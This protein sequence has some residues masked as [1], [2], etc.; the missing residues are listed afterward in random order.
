MAIEWKHLLPTLVFLSWRLWQ[1]CGKGM[2]VAPEFWM[3]DCSK[4][5]GKIK[6]NCF[7][8]IRLSRPLF[9]RCEGCNIYFGSLWEWTSVLTVRSREYAS[10]AR[11]LGE[12][13]EI[14]DQSMVTSSSQTRNPLSATY[15]NFFH[16]HLRGCFN[17]FELGN[18]YKKRQQ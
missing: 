3:G 10:A 15:R 12:Y 11:A 4:L 9:A 1:R 2:P 17:G 18:L 7:V 6:D 14:H 8:D 16:P 13:R 5:I